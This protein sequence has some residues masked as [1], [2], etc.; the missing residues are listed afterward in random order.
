M[1]G[2]VLSLVGG[3]L[4]ET[5]DG[6][7]FDSTCIN[8]AGLGVM[9]LF[10]Q[11]LSWLDQKPWKI[12]LEKSSNDPTNDWTRYA[13]MA[14]S[15]VLIAM[16]PLLLI[17]QPETQINMAESSGNNMSLPHHQ[18]APQKTEKAAFQKSPLESPDTL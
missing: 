4:L 17:Q 3:I 11:F 1:M 5:S 9:M 10:A 18:D 6:D 15:M 13:V 2:S 16:I 14:C 8:V 12:S 7:V